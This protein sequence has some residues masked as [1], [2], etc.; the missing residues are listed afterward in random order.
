[1]TNFVYE[2]RI[3]T[4]FGRCDCVN[5]GL[6]RGKDQCSGETSEKCGVKEKRIPEENLFKTR[7][8]EWR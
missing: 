4:E 7:I 6:N 3:Q 8:D 2:H 1:M 5:E